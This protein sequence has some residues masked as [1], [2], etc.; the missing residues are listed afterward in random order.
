MG[1]RRHLLPVP[2]DLQLVA[3][4]LALIAQDKSRPPMSSSSYVAQELSSLVTPKA[5]RWTNVSKGQHSRAV[6]QQISARDK[7]RTFF[8]LLSGSELDDNV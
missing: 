4:L 2:I 5:L 3:S 1:T 7:T 8:R 6:L